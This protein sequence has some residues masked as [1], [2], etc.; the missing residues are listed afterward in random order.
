[1]AGAPSKSGGGAVYVVFGSQHPGE[2]SRRRRSRSRATRTTPTN[3]ATP[4]PL[5]SRYDG[6]QQNSHTGMSLAAL[7][8]VNG[9]GYN[10]L[11]VGRARRRPAHPGG[12]GVAVLYGKPQG[13]HITLNDLWE[14]GY[15]YFFHI[16]FPD[17]RPTSTSA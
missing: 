3:P 17:A 6:F 10:D 5:G 2:R 14:N 1:M 4:S 7:P 12:G 16:D 13:V 15:P 8:D 9:D 11:A